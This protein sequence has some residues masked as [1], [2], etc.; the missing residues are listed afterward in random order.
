MTPPPNKIKPAVI[1]RALK[2][3]Q[4]GELK[5]AEICETCGIS[6]GTLYNYSK[7]Q[8]IKRKGSPRRPRHCQPKPIKGFSGCPKCKNVE[9]D[10]QFN[11]VDFCDTANGIVIYR[12]VACRGCRKKYFKTHD[13]RTGET[14]TFLLR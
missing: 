3:Y 11:G 14:K 4:D 5:T 6:W 1:K 8:G 2:L 10:P 13:N 7:Q 9:A 12:T